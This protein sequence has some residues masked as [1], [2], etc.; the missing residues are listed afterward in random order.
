MCFH[1][2]SQ[3]RSC[4]CSLIHHEL[5]STIKQF[6]FISCLLSLHTLKRPATHPAR[7][8]FVE[9]YLAW[10]VS[11]L[12]GSL[13]CPTAPC[14]CCYT[15]TMLLLPSWLCSMSQNEVPW[16]LW[17][18]PFC[19]RIFGLFWVFGEEAGCWDVVFTPLWQITTCV[20]TLWIPPNT[21]IIILNPRTRP[22]Q[23]LLVNG[24]SHIKRKRYWTQLFV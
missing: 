21:G 17:P 4:I 19:S 5:R 9:N 24:K 7:F 1:A 10:C 23:T 2:C 11:S 20:I 15:M 16:C 14:V 12:L 3:L 6:H 13:F 8:G 22:F 18:H